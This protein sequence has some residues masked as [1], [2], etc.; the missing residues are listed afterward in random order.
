MK[1]KMIICARVKKFYEDAVGHQVTNA[2][3]FQSLNLTPEQTD[4]LIGKLDKFYHVELGPSCKLTLEEVA[5]ICYTTKRRE[6]IS[7]MLYNVTAYEINSKEIYP[8]QTEPNA[9]IH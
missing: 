3:T 9:S 8:Q 1:Q 5:N 6:V 4:K 2:D 7:E